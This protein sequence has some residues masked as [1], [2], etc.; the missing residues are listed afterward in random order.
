M[1]IFT[2]LILPTHKHGGSFHFQ[3]PYISFFRDL[4]F[5][6][7]R[8]STSLVRLT[9]MYLKFFEGS[10]NGHMSMIHFSACL[11]L[12]YRKA[13]DFYKLLLYPDSWMTSSLDICELWVSQMQ[14]FML[15]YVPSG[16]T[17]S[18]TFIMKTHQI[19]SNTFSAPN[20]VI[21]C[22]SA[23]LYDLLLCMLNYSCVSTVK[24]TLSY[25][26]KYFIEIL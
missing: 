9:P 24:P 20:Y 12:V 19:L 13:T 3:S 17:F 11:L 14:T 2:I 16:P 21:F 1:V 23:H 4:T 10:M 5:S 22:L 6:L 8:T 26:C 18:R 25:F 7:Q 15:R